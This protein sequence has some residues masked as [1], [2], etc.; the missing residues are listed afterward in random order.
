MARRGGRGGVE[1]RRRV[2]DMIVMRRR[3]APVRW[4]VVMGVGVP[5]LLPFQVFLAHLVP[6]F[7]IFF[8]LVLLLLRRG[9][10]RVAKEGVFI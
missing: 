5:L 6:L 2:L 10:K 4:D 3:W 7:F 9:A 1:V 8:L